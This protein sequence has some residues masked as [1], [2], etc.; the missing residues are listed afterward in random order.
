MNRM[1]YSDTVFIVTIFKSSAITLFYFFAAFINLFE[2]KPTISFLIAVI[3][4][5]VVVTL[6]LYLI[7]HH[8]HD[9]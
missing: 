8:L 2:L 7:Y 9:R 1:S 4:T 3:I 6:S 5:I